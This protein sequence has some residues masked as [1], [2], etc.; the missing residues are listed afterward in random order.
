MGEN[1]RSKYFRFAVRMLSLPISG[2]VSNMILFD[3]A[4][5]S[6]IA[7]YDFPVSTIQHARIN[8]SAKYGNESLSF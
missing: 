2:A 7:R 5:V 4:Q 3:I 8:Y 1:I 6:L